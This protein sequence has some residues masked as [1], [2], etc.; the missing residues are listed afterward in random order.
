M[1]RLGSILTSGVSQ[2]VAAC[3]DLGP[4]CASSSPPDPFWHR[5]RLTS[6]ET[7]LDASLGLTSFLA[8]E[9]RMAARVVDIV[10]TY[11]ELDGSPKVVAFDPHHRDETLFGPTDPWVMARFAGSWGRLTASGRLG[12]TLPLGATEPDPYALGEQGLSHQHIQLGT[13]TVMPIVGLSVSGTVSR[14]ELGAS[15][16]GFFGLY[17]NEQGFRPPTRALF[18]TRAG[19]HFLD[20]RLVPSA[21]VDLLTESVE[22]WNGRPGD[23][24]KH[25]RADVLAGVGVSWVVGGP[26]TLDASARHRVGSLVGTPSLSSSGFY[27]V[28]V[29]SAFDLWGGAKAGTVR[30]VAPEVV[31]R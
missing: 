15:A 23:E 10:P 22:L 28:T 11:R 26:W 6:S 16:L 24:A 19:V 4:A 25:G 12:L 17:A 1:L 18:S 21:T 8:V 29:S 13:G 31:P 9:A 27:M 2:H 20:G 14:V 3:P 5:V 7:W 30:G